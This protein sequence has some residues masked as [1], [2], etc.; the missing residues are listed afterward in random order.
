[1]KTSDNPV[2]D[3][4]TTMVIVLEPSGLSTDTS[5]DDPSKLYHWR[6]RVLR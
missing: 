1:M 3:L 4:L 5:R 2:D 6:R